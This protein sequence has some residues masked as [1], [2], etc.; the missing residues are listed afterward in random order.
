LSL[1]DGPSAGVTIAWALISL[2]SGRPA[3]KDVGLT[4]EITL[5]GGILPV[6]GIREKVLAA[7]RAGLK[8]V[9][10]PSRNEE[11]VRNLPDGARDGLELVLVDNIADLEGIILT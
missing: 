3:R 10:F 4:G 5:N 8:V 6:S 1:T 9:A 7:Q 11:D 2:L